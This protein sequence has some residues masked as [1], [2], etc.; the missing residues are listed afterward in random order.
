V[1]LVRPARPEDGPA[2]ADL[3]VRSWQAAYRGL[4]P[5]D[6]LD[7]LRPEDR[8]GRYTLGSDDPAAPS[9]SVATEHDVIRGFVTTGPSRDLDGA[10]AGELLALYVD[11]LSWGL[12]VGRRLMEHARAQLSG[13]GFR[14]ATLGV[15]VGNDRALRFYRADGWTADGARR[16]RVVWGVAVHEECLRRT[17]S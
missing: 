3:H 5:D 6:Y 12:G 7:D 9:T 14:L 1:L 11:P 13:M 10:G 17:L 16:T 2:V 8:M 15:L 4:L